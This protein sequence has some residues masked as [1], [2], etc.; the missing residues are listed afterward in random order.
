MKKV[1]INIQQAIED[2]Y[3]PGWD[4]NPLEVVLQKQLEETAV[5]IIDTLKDNDM[6]KEVSHDYK[7]Y[8]NDL[9]NGRIQV[10]IKVIGE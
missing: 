1:N 5:S 3:V 6:L 2:Y 9:T 8:L 7:S 4:K 10:K